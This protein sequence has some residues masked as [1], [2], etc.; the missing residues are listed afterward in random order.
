MSATTAATWPDERVA[1]AANAIAIS[2]VAFMPSTEHLRSCKGGLADFCPWQLAPIASASRIIV[3][4]D[5]LSTGFANHCSGRQSQNPVQPAVFLIPARRVS[6]VTSTSSS[7]RRRTVPC[8][9]RVKADILDSC[10]W[11]VGRSR[12]AEGRPGSRSPPRHRQPRLHQGPE[13]RRRPRRVHHRADHARVSGQGSDARPGARGRA[14]RARRVGGRRADERAGA[15]SGR[16][17]RRAAAAARR[18]E[19]HRGRA[20]AR[21]AWAR[22]R[23]R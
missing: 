3:R 13:D 22:R 10:L 21:A 7:G 20:R 12:R 8:Y 16:R 11:T 4:S 23:S 5:R 6:R 17:R 19:H 14:A 18:Q 9:C 15:R 1:K 2:A